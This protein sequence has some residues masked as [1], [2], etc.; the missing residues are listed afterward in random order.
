MTEK[1]VPASREAEIAAQDERFTKLWQAVSGPDARLTGPLIR[2]AASVEA[3]LLAHAKAVE[4]VEAATDKENE[5]LRAQLQQAQQERDK[6][7]AEA[8]RYRSKASAELADPT[9]AAGKAAPR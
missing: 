3:P 5:S 2:F 4:M 8:D 6:A 1:P 9:L 7:N